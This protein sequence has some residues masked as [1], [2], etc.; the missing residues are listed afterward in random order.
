MIVHQLTSAEE[1]NSYNEWIKQHRQG[2]LWQSL[3]WK[4]Y[5]ESLGREMRF[6][7]AMEGQEIKASALVVIDKTIMGLS[8][9]D[10]QRG[11]LWAMGDEQCATELLQQIKSHA[12]KEKCI[13]IYF[14]PS[15][16]LKAH[17]SK[18]TARHEQPEATRILD[19]TLNDEALL[20]Q[21]HQKGRYNI[22]VAQKN[23]VLIKKSDDIDAYYELAKKTGGRDGFGIPSKKQLKAFLEHLPGSFLLLAYSEK[24]QRMQ[25]MQKNESSSESSPIAGLIGTIYDHTGIYY[26]GASDYEHRAL[27]APYLLQ[28]EAIQ[29][30]KKAGCTHYDLLGIAPPGT[31][32]HHAWAGI[33]SFKEKFGGTVVTYPPE[34]QIVLKPIMQRLLKIKRRL[35]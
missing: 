19:L 22:K 32:P 35:F 2:S 7:A 26:Y 3:E 14:S 33:S 8:T 25:R 20:A 12:S 30:C 24:M 5:Q 27:M 23:D 34:Q 6:Y 21:M 15:T 17:N 31:G 10:I 1:L 11:P 4:Q 29:H 13:S 28:W 18:P 16:Q 9:W